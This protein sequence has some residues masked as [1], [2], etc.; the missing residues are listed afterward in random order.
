[1]RMSRQVKVRVCSRKL[2]EFS[3]ALGISAALAGCA[4]LDNPFQ[5]T[6]P[7][8]DASG[9]Q[10]ATDN[11]GGGTAGMAAEQ[12]LGTSGGANAPAPNAG[13]NSTAAGRSGSANGPG[14]GRDVQTE[15]NAGVGANSGV[16]SPGGTGNGAGASDAQTNNPGAAPANN[17]GGA[18]NGNS[19]AGGTTATGGGAGSSGSSSGNGN[20]S[21]SGNGAAGSGSSSSGGAAGK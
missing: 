10:V 21:G 8:A 19:T 5:K 18:A 13:Y 12:P 3:C 7:M 14:S 15:N 16:I 9:Y 6:S 11:G 1:M 20:G 17:G 2:I 4:S